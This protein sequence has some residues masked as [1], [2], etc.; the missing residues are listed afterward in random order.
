MSIF[1]SYLEKDHKITGEALNVVILDTLIAIIAGII[2]IFILLCLR[3]SAGCG[4]VTV[5]YH[6]AECIPSYAGRQG[7]GNAVFHIYDICGTV[8]SYC[9]I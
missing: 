8:N 3:N 1:G 5:I 4:T 9:R 6:T 7:M 2:I